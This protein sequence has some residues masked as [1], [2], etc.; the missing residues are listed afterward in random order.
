M[1]SGRRSASR[2]ESESCAGFCAGLATASKVRVSPMAVALRWRREAV[3]QSAWRGYL[4]RIISSS[5]LA[6]LI[7]LPTTF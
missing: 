4:Y 5:V 7:Q 1:T 6:F 3:K 2:A